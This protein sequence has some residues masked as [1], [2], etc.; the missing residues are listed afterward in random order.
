[1]NGGNI[2]ELNP[3]TYVY[4]AFGERLERLIGKGSLDKDCKTAI[5]NH[6]WELVAE[7]AR[8][9]YKKGVEIGIARE[10]VRA[11]SLKEGER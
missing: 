5:Y 6:C 1:M 2:K 9:G 7:A 11:S 8:Q 10:M 4:P 3:D